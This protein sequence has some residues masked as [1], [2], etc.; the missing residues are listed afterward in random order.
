LPAVQDG[1]VAGTGG[2]PSHCTDKKR[3]YTESA[4]DCGGECPAC[5]L[6]FVCNTDTD[7]GGQSV[8]CGPQCYCDALTFTCV[9]NDCYDHKLDGAE[10]DL[11]CGGALCH[12]CDLGQH[13]LVDPDCISTWCDLQT[14]VCITD[15]CTDHRTDGDEGD[16]DCGGPTCPSCLP[17]QHCNSSADCQSGHFCNGS[18]KVCQ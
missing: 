14:L 8:G 10:T 13:C 12:P 2:V 1:S 9:Y 15:H 4:V 11:D 16:V 18:T 3:D 17:G 6:G 7:C 5:G